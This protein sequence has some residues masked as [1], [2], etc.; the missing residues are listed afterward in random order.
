MLTLIYVLLSS[1]SGG[2][3]MG[4]LQS[5]SYCQVSNYEHGWN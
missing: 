3:V 5:H 1:A 4:N 2:L